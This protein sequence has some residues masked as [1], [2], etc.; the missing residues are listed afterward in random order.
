MAAQGA[1]EDFDAAATGAAL[2]KVVRARALDGQER[3]R[4]AVVHPHSAHNYELR[5]WLAAC[6]IDPQTEV[7]LSILAPPLMP[8]ALA[9]GRVD[10][11]CAGEPWNTAATA[12]GYG[13]IVTTQAAIWQASPEKVLGVA[14]SWAEANPDVLASLLRALYRAAEW[15]GEASNHTTLAR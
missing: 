3:L 11:Y 8:D 4:F 5:Y 14:A 1:P 9:T 13:R 6:G 2:Q 15:C 10:G 12:R 7:E